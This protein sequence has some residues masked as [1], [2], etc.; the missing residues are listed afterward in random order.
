MML[1]LDRQMHGASARL[2]LRL[3]TGPPFDEPLESLAEIQ[4]RGEFDLVARLL[5]RSDAIA[6]QGRLAAR[7][8]VDHLVRAR[9]IQN[10]LRQLL[11]R[12]ALAGADVVELVGAK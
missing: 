3:M 6:H 5:W 2:H 12:S 1:S 8:I 4:T 7:G 11:K 9:Q 10:Q